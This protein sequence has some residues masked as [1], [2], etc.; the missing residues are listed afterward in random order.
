MTH[1][2]MVAG[3]TGLI[4]LT[5]LTQACGGTEERAAP[6]DLEP[7]SLPAPSIT[8]EDTPEE[9]TGGEEVPTVGDVIY[10]HDFSSPADGVLAGQTS[11][12]GTNVYG[13]RFAEYTENGTLVVRAESE[14]SDYVGGAN[15]EEL[16][17]DGRALT[18]LADVSIEVDAT[19]RSIGA[20]ANWGLACRRQRDSGTFYFAFVGD[21]GGHAGAG[22]VRQDEQRGAWTE[23]AT[24]STLPPG[25]TIG[26]GQ[27]NRLRLDCVGSRITLYADGNRVVEGTDTGFDSGGVAVFVNPLAT[28]SEVEFD[29]L[30]IRE[31]Q[32]PGINR[33]ITQ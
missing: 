31:T 20:G 2:R 4:T 14:L 15:T 21:A 27:A 25:V 8:P 6:L 7:I 13:T 11:D 5:L 22:I 12:T 16:I 29:N 10:E 23:V 24:A 17:V 19:P 33:S 9:E 3:I 30:V 28:A 18:D 32:R 26:E 1:S